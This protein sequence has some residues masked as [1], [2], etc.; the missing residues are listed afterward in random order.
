MYHYQ[1]KCWQNAVHVP[2]EWIWMCWKCDNFFYCLIMYF[3]SSFWALQIFYIPTKWGLSA[4]AST[5]VSVRVPI[6]CAPESSIRKLMSL[7][8]SG[9]F[10]EHIDSSQHPKI[11][12]PKSF[13]GSI[14]V[15]VVVVARWRF[16]IDKWCSQH[17]VALLGW[18]IHS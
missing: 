1:A 9:L 12:C 15:I 14:V 11:V 17:L 8:I 7:E 18:L 16:N 10:S 5:S 4:N 13:I 3:F 2:C 6:A